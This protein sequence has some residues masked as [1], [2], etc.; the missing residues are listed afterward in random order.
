[1]ID[2]RTTSFESVV[3][4]VDVVLDTMGGDVQTK[5]Y[6]VLKP[7]GYIV[8]TVHP[9]DA[10]VLE[11]Q[12]LR[13]SMV[14]VIPDTATLTEMARRASTGELTIVIDRTLPA[15]DFRAAFDYSITGRAQGKIILAWD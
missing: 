9:P 8:S 7:G 2:Y 3:R 4:G 11:A 13:G 15:S 10:S 14:R 1:M 6:D 5:S 12:G